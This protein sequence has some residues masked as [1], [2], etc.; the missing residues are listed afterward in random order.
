MEALSPVAVRAFEKL[1][2]SDTLQSPS[3]HV[4]PAAA[5]TESQ[6]DEPVLGASR[7]TEEPELYLPVG[8]FRQLL[9]DVELVD[10]LYCPVAQFRHDV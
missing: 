5:Q 9:D 6:E 3:T 4:R 1:V 7:H 2:A 10:G 8:Q